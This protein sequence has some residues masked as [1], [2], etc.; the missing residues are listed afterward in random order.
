MNGRPYIEGMVDTWIA[1]L[2]TARGD[3]AGAL[4]SLARHVRPSPRPMTWFGDLALEEFRR[5]AVALAPAEAGE[6]DPAGCRTTPRPGCSRPG[7]TS[8]GG[9]GA[10]AEQILAETE[11]VTIREQGKLEG[12]PEPGGTG[13]RPDAGAPLPAGGR[14]AAQ[15]HG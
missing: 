6:A 3:R 10:K 9:S 13:G 15:P 12:P 2:A 11:P 7:C 4:A 1:R 8:C 5:V 14:E